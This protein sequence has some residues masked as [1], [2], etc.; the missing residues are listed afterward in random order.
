MKTKRAPYFIQ[1]G[2][3]FGTAYSKCIYRD[4]GVDRAFIYQPKTP[5]HHQQP[6]LLPVLLKY[7]EN[8]VVEPKTAEGF[9]HAN[10]LS[11]LKMALF[12][13]SS[14][15][16]DDITVQRCKEVLDCSTD[17]LLERIEAATAHYLAHR[18][19]EIIETIKLQFQGF[20]DH[21]DDSLFL[22]LA[23]PVANAAAEDTTVVFQRV[24]NA[25]WMDRVNIIQCEGNLDKVSSRID[26]VCK[27]REASEY[28]YLYPEVSANVQAYVRSR[29]A[30]SGIYLFVDTGA[31]TVDE[32]VFI[33][34]NEGTLSLAYLSACVKP[35][36]SSQIEIRAL[37][38]SNGIKDIEEFRRQKEAGQLKR[39]EIQNAIE[40]ISAD[41]VNPT[42][43]VLGETYRK[44]IN[45]QHIKE[46]RIIFTGGGHI[47]RPYGSGVRSGISEFFNQR[48]TGDG[49]IGGRE[50]RPPFDPETIPAIGM[51]LPSDLEFPLRVNTKLWFK[52]LTVAY[53]LS[54]P[55]FDLADYRLPHE[56][57]D[58]VPLKR[59]KLVGN[60]YI[61]N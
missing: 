3:D 24:V 21:I 36:G 58:A 31:G 45:T 12:H 14:R 54:F 51:P 56:I 43:K 44:G 46:V 5:Y 15:N 57:R 40:S 52:R 22:N 38:G 4:V 17:Q 16:F 35:L 27:A 30:K 59:G 28:C 19:S 53:G 13:A 55:R 9:H 20:G 34:K 48:D 23:I 26:S 47:D 60:E 37:K 32:S 2:F 33:F 1:I 41:L 10:H 7:H 39:I 42:W 49:Y 11:L 8:K 25:A 29:T 6:F 50:Y 18:F 61:E